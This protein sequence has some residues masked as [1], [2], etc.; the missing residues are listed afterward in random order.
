[1]KNKTAYNSITAINTHNRGGGELLFSLLKTI[2]LFFILS[3]S[4]LIE[5]PL[6]AID[7]SIEGENPTICSG[8]SADFNL[9]ISGNYTEPL[10]IIWEDQ[11]ENST[12]SIDCYSCESVTI[13]NITDESNIIVRVT[14]GMGFECEETLSF[15]I[16]NYGISFKKESWDSVLDK[17]VYEDISFLNIGHWGEDVLDNCDKVP[18]LGV[19]GYEGCEDINTPCDVI[20][21]VIDN[22]TETF[23][24]KDEDRFYI[25]VNY[26][27]EQLDDG[28]FDIIEIEIAT[29][30]NFN[31]SDNSSNIE[32]NFTSYRLEETGY[33]TQ[34]FRSEA[35]LLTTLDLNILDS[36]GKFLVYPDDDFPVYS[37]AFN[38]LEKVKV[39]DDSPEGDRTHQVSIDGG[40]YVKLFDDATFNCEVKIPVCDRADGSDKGRKLL[41]IRARVYLNPADPT[42][43][44]FIGSKT[45]AKKIIK[46][47]IQRANLSWAQACIKVEL[48]KK[49]NGQDDIIFEDPPKIG[50]DYVT[51][52]G[53]DY[54]E[55]V[56]IMETI[57]ASKNDEEILEVIF[58]N[59]L[60]ASEGDAGGITMAPC[61]IHNQSEHTFVFIAKGIIKKHHSTVLTHEIGHALD[62]ECYEGITCTT[63]KKT[64][65]ML[66]YPSNLKSDLPGPF[67][68]NSTGDAVTNH[69]RLPK[70]REEICRTWRVGD[71]GNDDYSKLGNRLLQSY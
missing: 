2:L 67:P 59:E 10:Y 15:N 13:D 14:D 41:K 54:N 8:G 47:Q 57:K 46:K 63:D 65:T 48:N 38:F 45:E 22:E 29:L 53:V 26:D 30:K 39:A 64:N 70:Y 28:K 42:G 18:E 55:R 35:M 51:E 40:V 34:I 4:S 33:N 16:V 20:N 60:G 62:N 6:F 61:Q 23:I 43:S 36:F 71:D 56:E 3:L 24:D 37:K 52:M 17:Y 49:A 50:N 11:G 9:T 58:L 1:M 44:T 7:I 5:H 19:N 69:R 66:F 68:P 27:S 31:K 25:E 21:D 12:A 32:D